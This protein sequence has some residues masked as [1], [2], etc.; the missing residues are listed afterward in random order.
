MDT[1]P[2]GAARVAQAFRD[3]FGAP[4]AVVRSPGR[5]NLIGEHTDHNL[6]FVLPGAVDRAIF[7]AI[8]LRDDRALRFT[9]LDKAER[10]AGS[11]DELRPDPAGWPTYLLGILSELSAQ[12]ALVRGVDCV[13]GGDV[14]IGS[15]MSSSAAL[16]CG[17]AFGLNELLGLGQSR[18]QLALLSQR[19]EN[20][21]V[22]VACGIMDPFASCLGRD[23]RLIRLDC[24]DL[25]YQYVPFERDDIRIV[26]CDT[27]L[28]R[29]LAGS[30]YNDRRAQCVAG[31]AA[32]QTRH[33]EIQSLR[34]ATPALVEELR[35]AVDDAV[36]RR[37]AYV[38]AEND[39][40][41]AACAALERGDFA[42]VGAA[43]NQT[44]E[45]LA[46]GYEVSCPELDVLAAAARALPGV[47]GARMM[48]AGFGGCTINLVESAHLDAF[49]ERMAP[50]F[51][52]QLGK[53]P[54]I[55]VCK[56]SA[57]TERLA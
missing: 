31:V 50:V 23:K 17:F 6:G 33:P 49:H 3:E 27:Q 46:H 13:F 36:Y 19:S 22:G 30:A 10:F 48:G 9:A 52:D 35:G 53:P 54:K 39:R 25:S 57:G 15:G 24:R 14:P 26:L 47:H 12:G 44:H 29:A 43:M 41:L 8:G 20:R 16:E 1:R 38:V 32:L 7:L 40:V 51:R 34:D 5:I 21:F 11:L 42:A 2:D 28:P 4:A 37:C 55:H 18:E 45:G 56:L